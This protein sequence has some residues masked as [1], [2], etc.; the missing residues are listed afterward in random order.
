M[1]NRGKIQ[2]DLVPTDPQAPLAM[3]VK[4]DGT[5]VWSTDALTETQQ[6]S[7]T[8]LDDQEG[9]HVLEWIL[10][11]KTQHHTKIDAQGNIVKDSM[12]S[13][14]N[15]MVEE[16]DISEWLHTVGTYSHDKNGTD[17]MQTHILYIDLGC[18]GVAAMQF[19]SPIY[20]WLL[21]KM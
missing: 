9:E 20:L 12:I 2:F 7:V 10:S 18:N 4:L 15:V 11:G 17:K 3:A 16:I 6:V 1:E 14:Q 21:E 13:L 19:T 8:W 5:T